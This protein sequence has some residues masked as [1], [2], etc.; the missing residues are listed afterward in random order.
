MGDPEAGA[1]RE[2]G[3]EPGKATRVRYVVLAFT[4][5]LSVITYIDRVCI[6][7][8]APAM[9][10]EL[11]L[12]RVQ[13]GLVFSAFLESGLGHRLRHVPARRA[14]VAAHRSHRA[15]AQAA[16]RQAATRRP[17]AVSRQALKVRNER[18]NLAS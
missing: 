6:S 5:L 17:S 9:S 11:H 16:W 18:A 13:M 2:R 7:A 1:A 8:A 4:F 10:T 3:R 15:G 14:A 12:S